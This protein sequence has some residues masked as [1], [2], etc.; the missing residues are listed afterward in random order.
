MPDVQLIAAMKNKNS[1]RQLSE[2][3]FL[4]KHIS[5]DVFYH[6]WNTIYGSVFF[7]VVYLNSAMLNSS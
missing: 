4:C 7:V 2:C 1:Y 5:Y 3:N 6:I